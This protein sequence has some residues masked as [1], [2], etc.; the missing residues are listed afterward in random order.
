MNKLG[1]IIALAK[2]EDAGARDTFLVHILHRFA[3]PDYIQTEVNGFTLSSPS[4]LLLLYFFHLR[5][6]LFRE[7]HHLLRHRLYSSLRRRAGS[8]SRWSRPLKTIPRPE[9]FHRVF[10]TNVHKKK[11]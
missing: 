1:F 10:Y 3:Y 2:G 7:E 5:L 4:C 6:I 9:Y 8:L 11:E